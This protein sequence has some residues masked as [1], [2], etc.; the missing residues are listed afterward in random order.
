MKQYTHHVF[1]CCQE[2]AAGEQA[3]RGQRM[4]DY[5]KARIKALGIDGEGKC[6]VNTAGCLGRC[7]EGPLL[8]VYPEGVWY[9]WVDEEDLEE[10][11]Q[12][13]LIGNQ[14]VERLLVPEP[15]EA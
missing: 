11:I 2:R 1:V 7:A 8:V 15:G 9:N 14:I 12:L 3:C 10:I 6:R 5:A 13:H 4:R